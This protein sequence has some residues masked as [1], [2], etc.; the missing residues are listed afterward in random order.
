MDL[1]NLLENIEEQKEDRKLFTDADSIIFM[2]CFKHKDSQDD[3]LAYMDFIKILNRIETEVW[4]KYQ[5]IE[6][7]IGITS[8]TNFRYKLYSDYKA[9]RKQ[10]N[11]D[12][13]I[14]SQFT[15]RV[16]KLIYDRLKP[17]L[18][19]DGTFET[20]DWAI[21]YSKQGWIVS[22]IDS[23]VV[24]QSRTP[25]FNYHSKHWCW[26]HDGLDDIT[27]NT[28]IMIDSIA[29]KSKDNVVG[30][31]GLGKAK[32]SKFI[33]ELLDGKKSFGDYVDLFPTPEDM[34]LSYQLCDCGQIDDDGKLK[35]VSVK[36]IE[37]RL[38]D[39]SC[40]F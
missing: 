38:L 14:L 4:K 35:L 21:Y 26:V 31:K 17:I 6:T 32:A 34:L 16:K 28:N 2:S 24:G 15:K 10:K 9:N 23:D 27:I 29:G 7:K 30:V 20:D 8:S 40:P 13:E 19:C 5:L 37:E 3:E 1:N 11:E 36:D 25:V 39:I 12:A 22:A 33:N 18:V